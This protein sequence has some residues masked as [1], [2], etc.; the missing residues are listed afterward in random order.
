MKITWRHVTSVTFSCV[1]NICFLGKTE[2]RCSFTTMTHRILPILHDVIIQVVWIHFIYKLHLVKTYLCLYIW[3]F[4]LPCQACRGTRF[5]VG[6]LVAEDED[7]PDAISEPDNLRKIPVEADFLM[8]YSVVPG[9]H[10][11]QLRKFPQILKS[12]IALLQAQL[13][14]L[15]W[16]YTDMGHLSHQCPKQDEDSFNIWL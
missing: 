14:C 10:V 5:D 8:A 3:C 15:Y 9:M 4:C 12:T 13:A 1:Y 6:A 7:S 2:Y 11:P 16:Y